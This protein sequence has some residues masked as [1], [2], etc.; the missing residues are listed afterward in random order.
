MDTTSLQLP[1]A[2]TIHYPDDN[3]QYGVQLERIESD[4]TLDLRDGNTYTEHVTQIESIIDDVSGLD[5]IDD[6]LEIIYG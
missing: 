5:L 6:V 3:P 4:G 2:V 1:V